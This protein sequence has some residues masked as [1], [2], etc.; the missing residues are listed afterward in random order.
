MK[1]HFE[2]QKK[3]QCV[4]QTPKQINGTYNQTFILSSSELELTEVLAW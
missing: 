3:I 1:D 2:R 4:V